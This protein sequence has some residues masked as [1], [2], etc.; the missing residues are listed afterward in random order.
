MS[1][2]QLMGAFRLY[3]AD[4]LLLALGVTF[5]TSL[6]KNT[7]MK[8]LNKKFFVFLPF[9]LGVVL[10]AGYRLLLERDLS[11]LAEGICSTLEGGFGCGCAATLY[12]VVWE[13]FLRGKFVS[14]PLLP[15]LECVPEK[16]RREAAAKLYSE[17]KKK[18]EGERA[19]Y[20]YEALQTYSDPPM[21]E[22]ELAATAELLAEFMNSL[23]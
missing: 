21:S 3:G 6:L 7:V 8:N 17:A 20:F 2:I 12:Y 15:L 22:T 14:S 23:D 16:R 9:L 11:P 19:A 4:V 13:Q 18:A 1:L 10:Y 5:L